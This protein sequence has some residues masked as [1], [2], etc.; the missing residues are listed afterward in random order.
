MAEIILGEDNTHRISKITSG[1]GGKGILYLGNVDAATD[2]KLLKSLHITSVITIGSEL[3]N[4]Y[5]H[6]FPHLK[7]NLEDQPL[8]YIYHYFAS[9]HTFLLKHLHEGNVL[10]HCKMGIS[11]SASIVI[12]YLM[13]RYHISFEKVKN[14]SYPRH[15]IK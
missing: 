4:K 3:S 1:K 9:S 6:H 5:P 10:V 14:S 15:I 13:R 7:I 12:A 2:M 11:R 8:A